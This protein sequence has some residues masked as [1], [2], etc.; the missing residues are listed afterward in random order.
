MSNYKE[1][2]GKL[3]RSWWIANDRVREFSENG[4]LNSVG[5]DFLAIRNSISDVILELWKEGK[6]MKKVWKVEDEYLLADSSYE[7][8]CHYIIKNH[9]DWKTLAR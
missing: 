9:K 6:P 7:D 3:E 2:L 4:N 8:E 1:T 5:T